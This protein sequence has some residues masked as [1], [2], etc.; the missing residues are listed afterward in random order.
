M[1]SCIC[2]DFIVFPRISHD[3]VDF[4]W[5]SRARGSQHLPPFAIGMMPLKKPLLDPSWLLFHRFSWISKD[6]MR[7]HGQLAAIIDSSD[8]VAGLAGLAG[9]AGWLAG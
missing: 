6:F 3:F 7:F 5:I 1:I 4:L 9:L 8:L 2:I